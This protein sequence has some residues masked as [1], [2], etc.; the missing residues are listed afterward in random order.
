MHGGVAGLP[1]SIP[2]PDV[3]GNAQQGGTSLT[4]LQP[5][6]LRVALTGQSSDAALAVS[7]LESVVRTTGLVWEAAHVG[8]Q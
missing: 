4:K 6:P 1:S 3:N 5:K 8:G 2:S 7:R